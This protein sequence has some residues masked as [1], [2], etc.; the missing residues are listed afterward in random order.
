MDD[1]THACCHDVN[2]E[3]VAGEA[4]DAVTWGGIDGTGFTEDSYI[5]REARLEVLRCLLPFPS[6]KLLEARI[7]LHPGSSQ[8]VSF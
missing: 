3:K 2:L 5:V 7:L 6:K 1:D 4:A 8:L